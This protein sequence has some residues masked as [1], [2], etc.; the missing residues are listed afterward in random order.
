MSTSGETP[1][2]EYRQPRFE[3]PPGSTEL[4]L[5]RHGESAPAVDGVPFPVLGAHSDPDLAPEGR[6]QAERVGERLAKEHIDAIYV[7]TLRRTA[8]TAEPLAGRLGLTPAVEAD[9]REVLLGEWEGGLLRKRVAENHPTAQR[10]WAEQRWDVIPGAEP[11]P[12]FAARVRGAVERLVAAHPDERLAVFTH[13]GVIAAVLAAATGSEPFAFI[14]ADN[15]SISGLV[16][17]GS[18]WILRR[19]NDIAHLPPA[20]R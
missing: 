20:G 2:T 13:G 10:L 16:V 11:A 3:A 7:T 6:Q 19:F 8:Q 5:I 12:E 1:V 18:R 4:L 17:H 14:G 9:L 15:A